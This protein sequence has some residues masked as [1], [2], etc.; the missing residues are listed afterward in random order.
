MLHKVLSFVPKFV[1]TSNWTGLIVTNSFVHLRSLIAG[2]LTF[3]DTRTADKE[4][5]MKSA[6]PQLSQSHA[7][8]TYECR[9]SSTADP[10]S[11]FSQDP[12]PS[13]DQI[14]MCSPS[15][16][17]PLDRKQPPLPFWQLPSL[18]ISIQNAPSP[19]R[20]ASG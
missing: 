20:S 12:S 15:Y 18:L 2:Q 6:I 17:I 5:G 7:F 14:T 13:Y 11:E 8:R 10:N 1:S 3:K 16:G 9:K 4:H 19:N